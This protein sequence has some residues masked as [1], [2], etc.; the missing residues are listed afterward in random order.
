MHNT[1]PIIYWTLFTCSN[2]SQVH[3]KRRKFEL[4]S[5][6]DVN[7]ARFGESL[8]EWLVS[9]DTECRVG[10]IPGVENGQCWPVPSPSIPAY[11]HE[12]WKGPLAI[13][14]AESEYQKNSDCPLFTIQNTAIYFQSSTQPWSIIK[15]RC[16]CQ[17]RQCP[18]I[19]DLLCAIAKNYGRKHQEM[20]VIWAEL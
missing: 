12:L 4:S 10:Q 17:C 14:L 9:L 3:R 18:A 6:S 2:I 15:C 11:S 5:F 19:A 13:N 8:K 7:T 16:Q 20:C 1:H